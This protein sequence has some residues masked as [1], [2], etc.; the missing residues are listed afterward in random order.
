[1]LEL[2][3]FSIRLKHPKA[4]LQSSSLDMMDPGLRYKRNL[5]EEEDEGSYNYEAGPYILAPV[6]P[7]KRSGACMRGCLKMSSLHPAQC[8]SLC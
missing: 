2:S 8:N 6:M 1:M 4:S 5:D 3:P 7:S